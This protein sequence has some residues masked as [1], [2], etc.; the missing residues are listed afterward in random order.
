MALLARSWGHAVATSLDGPGAL[1]M[2][3]D[4]RPD[5]ALVDIRMPG[6]DGYELARR[7]RQMP[8]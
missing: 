4:F 6:M 5:I 3:E 7:L 1:Q 8:G 2:A